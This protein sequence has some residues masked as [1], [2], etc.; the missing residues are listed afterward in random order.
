MNLKKL[1]YLKE[2]DSHLIIHF[3]GLRLMFKHRCLFK[4]KPTTSYGVSDELRTPKLVV[5]LT[6]FPQRID[7]VHLAINTLLRQ[8]IKPNVLILWLA[9][10]QFPNGEKE[11]PKS[12][13]K[14]KDFGL[15]IDWCED[16]KSY[17]KLIPSLKKYPNDIIITADDDL[18]YEEDWLESL[19]GTYLKNPNNIYVRRAGRIMVLENKFKTISNR[20]HLYTNY[21]KPS[22]KNVLLGGS[23]CLFPPDSLHEDIFNVEKIK[24][25]L[26][27]Q[28]DFYFWAMAVLKKTKIGVVK[29]FD[30]H[31]YCI[32][33]SQKHG[34][35]KINRKN[36]AAGL[37]G[38]EACEK[39]LHTYP[40]IMDILKEE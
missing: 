5:S 3:L 17:K 9:R 22:Y 29:G 6:S 33:G 18:C 30:A 27:T 40:E 25:L 20:K 24:Y 34:L 36:N 8:S 15:T 39:L 37:S 10:E 26:P 32:E 28:D 16:L 14:L 2:L 38:D 11:L 12:L 7:T 21:F 35:C 31:L 13:L 19:Y 23:G 1:F 4:Y